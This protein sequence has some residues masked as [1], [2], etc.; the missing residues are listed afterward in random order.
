MAEKVTAEELA[1]RLECLGTHMPAVVLKMK[2]E[3]LDEL[4]D[5]IAPEE[6]RATK[7]FAPIDKESYINSFRVKKT[8]KGGYVWNKAKHAKWV[9]NGR[10]PGGK[11]G[12]IYH[13]LKASG[14]ARR[15]GVSGAHLWAIAQKIAKKGYAPRHVM[16][17][18]WKKAEARLYAKMR[19]A[20]KKR[21]TRK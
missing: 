16:R 15:K 9:E 14:W 8:D 4:K 1:R 2:H 11:P 10:P 7:P 3:V 12:S 18:A 17:R 5:K 19:S 13:I 6:A 21:L 20:L